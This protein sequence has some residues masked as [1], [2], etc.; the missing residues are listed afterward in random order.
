[1]PNEFKSTE[2]VN[3][4]RVDTYF[5]P[6]CDS[7]HVE[8]PELEGAKGRCYECAF[9]GTRGEFLLYPVFTE[10]GVDL[11]SLM[12]RMVNRSRVLLGDPLARGLIPLLIE[13][14]F[15]PW[16][17][18]RGRRIL[19]EDPRDRA[20]QQQ[21]LGVYIGNAAKAIIRSVVLSRAEVEKIRLQWVA[22][23]EQR[24]EAEKES[25]KVV[26]IFGKGGGGDC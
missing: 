21:I 17:T 16:E 3:L 2:A 18:N 8:V 19:W 7:P 5:C 13:F 24:K 4:S 26:S 23:M 15:I 1:M 6:K 12:Q 25:R 11:P 20:M 9:E 10:A 22:D 14:G